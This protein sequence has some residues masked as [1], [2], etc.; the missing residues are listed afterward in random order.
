MNDVYKELL[1]QYFEAKDKFLVWKLTPIE[2]K[3]R[4]AVREQSSQSSE[5]LHVGRH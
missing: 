5:S 4:E 2:Q 1:R 3:L